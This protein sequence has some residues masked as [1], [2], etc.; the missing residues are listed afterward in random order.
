MIDK[1]FSSVRITRTATREELTA[2]DAEIGG[3]PASYRV[4]AEQYGTGLTNGMILIFMPFPCAAG[5]FQ[6]EGS[7]LTDILNDF[8]A[9]WIA[10]GRAPG[11]LDCL[12]PYDKQSVGVAARYKDLVFFG[13]SENGESF[14]WLRTD[15][16]YKFYA[17]DR[18]F[19][20]MRYGGD[21]LMTMIGD[22]QTDKVKAI[23]GT[24]YK[25]LPSSFVGFA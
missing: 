21:D 25:P 2:L 16:R 3:L 20:S 8:I 10:D 23:L 6:I 17:L 24:G 13:K 1:L 19:L 14:C 7:G 22:M 15:D 9:D 11:E 18:A 5:T 12:E 4:F